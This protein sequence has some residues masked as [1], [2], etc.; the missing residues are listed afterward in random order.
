MEN[1]RKK[2]ISDIAN[3]LGVS[4]TTVSRA[5]SGKGRI[6]EETREKVFNYI[7]EVN[8]SPNSIAK[9]LA[10]SKTFN[11]AIAI[12]GDCNLIELPFFQTCLQGVCELAN[13][14]D[15]DVIVTNT[16]ELNIAGVE[17]LVRNNK[18]DGIILSRTF[19]KDNAVRY[20]KKTGIP[21]VTIG[22]VQD[23]GVVQVDNDHEAACRELTSILLMKKLNR[24]ALIGGNNSHVVTRM[25]Y[26][27]FASAFKEHGRTVDKDLVYMGADT[28]SSIDSIVDELLEKKA[29]CIICMDDAICN[30]VLIK[31]GKRKIKVPDDIKIASFYNSSMLENN[32]PPITSLS[33]DVKNLGIK[34]CR[35]LLDMVDGKENKDK[36]L[37]GYEVVLKESTQV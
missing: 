6:S 2:T 13:S 9:S 7:A 24:I 17:R 34:C 32:N 37:L 4:K 21:F 1:G 8:Y 18:V 22:R 15:Y 33:F 12:P 3:E 19:F 35:T 10:Q 14:R 31:L 25:R 28:Y 29:E 26:E 23:E 27:G 5:I 11:I 36:V 30:N 16:T 20:L